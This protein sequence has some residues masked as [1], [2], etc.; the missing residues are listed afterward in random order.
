MAFPVRKVLRS[1]AL[2]A[3]EQTAAVEV[4]GF[5]RGE[6]VAILEADFT[7][8]AGT[9][10]NVKL[11]TSPDGGTTW[12]DLPDAAFTQVGEAD[13]SEAIRVSN[14]GTHVRADLSVAGA[15]PQFA[16]VRVTLVGRNAV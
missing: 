5:D 4:W 1:G 8:G 9:T 12:V 2:S 3:S 11:Q 13:A 14:A 6:F 10:L 7:S 16:N 15:T